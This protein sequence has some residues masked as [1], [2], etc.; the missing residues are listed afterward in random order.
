MYNSKSEIN[1][2]GPNSIDTVQGIKS[3]SG[4]FYA[5]GY[6]TTHYTTR[7]FLLPTSKVV[8]LSTILGQ[9]INNWYWNKKFDKYIIH[10]PQM[11]QVHD[12]NNYMI[13]L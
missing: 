4:G 1:S 10:I 12:K 7:I 13:Q 9:T 8:L 5:N 11:R 2:N 3:K 6:Y